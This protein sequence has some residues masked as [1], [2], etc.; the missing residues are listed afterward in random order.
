MGRSQH[1]LSMLLPL[2]PLF[3]GLA[4]QNTCTPAEA[5]RPAKR[6]DKKSFLT[7]RT[8][9]QACSANFAAKCPDGY[10]KITNDSLGVRDCRYSIEIRAYS[11]SVPG[12]RHICR[13]DYLQPQC[14]PGHWG[15]DCMECPGGA[16]SPC[17]GR[18]T[19]DEGMEG[20]GSCSCRAGFRGT[21]CETCEADNVFGPNCSSVC[22][23]V[24]GVCNS[25][26]HGDGTCECFSAYRGP[27]C[28]KPIPE[29]VALLCPENS[30]CSPSSQ[31]ETKLKCKC[32]PGY[33]GDGQHCKPINPC[34]KSIC[35][36]HA[37]CTYLGPN[38]H[39][40]SCQK[41]YRGDGQVCLPV[42]PCQTN[43]GNCSTKSTVCKY[44]GP[45]QSHCEC[46]EHYRDFVPGV[47]CS[48]I[49]VC[50]SNNPCHKNANCS[51][52]APGQARCTCRKGYMGDGLTCYGN[53][54][55]RLRE[56]N[57]E[58]RG[59]WQGRLTSFISIL[60]RTYAWPLSNLGPFTV[61]LP[62]DKGLKGF[63][64]KE[65]L[66][67]NEVTR[68][69]V[70]LHIIAGQMSTGQMNDTATF[71]TLTGKSGEIFNRDKDSQLKLKLD[72]GEK[73]KIIQGD[74][75]ASNGLIH[76][77][78]RAMDK[79]EPT[80]ESNPEQTIMKILQPRFSRFSSLL[81]KTNVGHVLDEGGA[82]GP[83]TVFVP[84]NEALDSM[85]AGTIDYLLSP[86]GS[87]KLLELVRYH[88]VAFTQLEVAT[89]ISTPHIRT[90]A[91][92]L[93]HF[94]TTRN[95]RILVNGV[96][97]EETEVAAKNGRIYTL[98][99]VLVPPSIVPILPHRCDETKRET[100]LGTCVSCSFIRWSKCP[101][102]SEP[103]VL[104]A[105]NCVYRTR[106]Q[107]LKSGCAQYCNAT[108]KIPKCCSGFFGP[109]CNPCP[110]G[111]LNPCS[112][113]GQCIDGLSGNGTCI[114]EDGFQGSRCQ[115]CSD[116]NRYGPRCNRTCLC[117]HGACD[118]RIDSDGACLSGT[119]REGTSGRFC[120]KKPSA[121]GPYVQLCH[122]HATCEYN[123]GTAS[124]VCNEG[125]EGDGTLCSKKDPC[126]G[127]TSRG[128]CSPNADCIR[129]GTGAHVCVCQQGWTGDGRD[130]VAINNCLLPGTGGCHDNA[131]C[132]YVG[133]GQNECECKKGFRGNGIDCEPVISCLEQA[134]KCHPLATC[135]ADA[136]GVWSC[137]CREG[138]EGNGLLCYGNVL[139]ELSR[140]SEAAAFY[141]W[142]ND[143]SL[144][145]MLSATP[146]LTVLVPS[147]Q[148]IE[149]MDKNERTFWLSRNNIPALI[150]YHTVRGTYGGADLQNLSSS[151]MLATSLQGS[152]LHLDKADGNITIEGASIVDGDSAAT[153]GVIHIINKVLV[154]QRSL[155]GSLPNLLTRLDQMPD[156]SIFR[157]YIIQYNLAS[158]IEAADAYT[159]FAPNNKAIESYIREKKA[160]TLEE[161]ILRYHV[162]LEEKLLKNDLHN[163]MHRETML[164]FSYLLGFFLHNDQLYVN[165]API[166][167]SN[168]ATDK[169]VIHGLGKVLEIQKNRCDENNSSIVR[170]I[171][172]KCSQEAICPLGTKPLG[173]TRKCIYTIYFMGKRSV[174]LGCQPKCVRT[175]ITKACCAGFFGPQCQACPRKDQNVCSGNGFCLDGV[176][177]VG[178]CK[179][180]QGFN[181]TACETCA[182]GKYGVHCD[183]ACACVH[184]RCSQG[185]S[186]DGSCDCEVGWRGV[187]CDIEITKDNCNGTCHTSA[188]CLLDPDGKASCKCAAGFQGNGTFCT[189]INACEVSNGGCS[190]KADCKRTTPGNRVCVCKAGYTGDGIVCLEI[191]PCLENNGGC[192]KNAECTQTGPNQAI[193]NC[194][195]KF[196]G[197]GKACTLINVC[198]TN[199]GG[200]S[201][202]ATCT[203]TGQDE[204]IC[205]CKQN[206]TGDG[207]VCRS[208]IYGEL[209]KNPTTS[210]YFFQL[211]E[212]AVRELAGPGPF[213]VFAPSS[214]S[215]NQESRIKDWDA[216]GLMSQVLRYHVV[217]CQQLLL[218]NLKVTTSAVTLQGEPIAIS[219]SQGTVFIN[220][221][222]V[223]SGDMISTNGVIHIIDRLLSPQNLLVTPKDASGR[224][225]NLT[226][227]A[228]NHSYTRFSKLIQDSGLLS[229]I[230]DPIHT[231]VTLF[232]PTDKALQALPPEQRDFLFDQD[233][234]DKLKE[235]L[236]FHVIR[237]SKALASDLP[238]SASWK[239][240]QGSELSV[241]CGTGRDVG[242][243]FLNGQ[244]CRIIQRG[245]LF[246]LGV[247]YGIDCLLTNPTLGGR[248]D[249]FTTFNISGDCGSCVSTPR[250][251]PWSKPK[252]VKQ[253][254]LYNP[255]PFGRN[256]EGCRQLCTLVIRLPRCCKGYF[257]PHCQ[258][259]PGGPDTPCNNRGVC[260][261]LYSTAGQCQCN[262]G[263]NGTACELCWPGRFGPDCQPCGCSEHGQCDE[264]IAG[265]GQCF[266][267][268]GWTGRF[269]DTLTVV[270]P[271]CIPPC[272]VHAT[273]MENNTCVCNLNYEGDGI[274]CT[275]VDFCKQN[276]GGCAK[277]AK[278][279][280]QGTRVS[281]SCKK[282]YQGDGYSCT[283]VDPCADGINGGCHEHATCR[284][285]GPGR[286]KCECKSHYVGDGVDCEPEQLPLDRCLQDNG[287]CHP[288]ANCADLHFQDTTVGVF[289]LRSPLGQY[290][291]TFD[292]AKEACANEAASMAT[293]NQLSYAQKASYHLCSAGWLESGR[294]A[295]PTTYASQKCGSNVVGI[296]DYGNRP[297]RSEMWDV[298]C[299]RMKDVNCTCKVGYVGDGF[300]CSGNMLQVLMSLSSLTDFLA[301]VLAYSN[302]SARGRAFLEHLT[303]LS[304]RGTLF[305]PQNSG[306]ME[307]KS[308]S[309]RDIEHHLT[310]VSISFYDDL[311][312]GTVLRTRLGS[313][314]LITSR[315]DQ[316]HQE[317]RFVDGRA[318]LQWDII[319]SNGLIHVISEPL[320]A[321]HVPASPAHTSLGTGVVCAVILVTGAI[322]LVAYSYFRL[323]QR[324]TGFQRFESEEDIDV[325]A[326]GKQHPENVANPVYES[327]S[328]AAPESS[329]DP[330]PDAE[331]QEV[332]SSDP[333][334][335]LRP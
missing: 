332:E 300:S 154:P 268:A 143:A 49:N 90:M 285:T 236:K 33:Q 104:F 252:G 170:G 270:F 179:C 309:G 141:Q 30:R 29:C 242:E 73:V 325:L 127:S 288:D 24:H 56:L 232:W 119:C 299:Y 262:T 95:G 209:P 133:P 109:D 297:N 276:N 80:L 197:D 155:T 259:C 140:L 46:K 301:E 122:I 77:L 212:H 167:Y 153:N 136:S 94:N 40:C 180:E 241:T 335:A 103:M 163:G 184:G 331:E 145:S 39:R 23:C 165:D 173:E 125:Y 126:I 298:F 279:S 82:G 172:G 253:K 204:R 247:A 112:G 237:D 35:H 190:A 68:Y 107:N 139:V 218:E 76:I 201:P 282:G 63:N 178:T 329:C 22:S 311:T 234:K 185:P 226:T 52:V 138:Y 75:A 118:N 281:C 206:Y 260:R 284:M 187:H 93:V 115:F 264:G 59:M 15:P 235:Y 151:N 78:D 271:V 327:S 258:A 310:N 196:T 198:L 277:A 144:Q 114:C 148:A 304:I 81:E 92:Q 99:G 186:G 292:K 2:I 71:Y 16:E 227:V 38:R 117:V 106:T 4:V 318:I 20:T 19:C 290:K 3:L 177:G 272:S 129:T 69:F 60:D 225:L 243:L 61:L 203:H 98:T 229:V 195:P 18:G 205:T 83:Y 45:G 111:F 319:A 257:L 256:L 97:V 278:C 1:L 224:V 295:Y 216:Q 266:C 67:N 189:A 200:C 74:I 175:V 146:N 303:D 8:E 13:K 275:A 14:C 265:S 176:N 5:T 87:R 121:C 328:S 27:R 57:M 7:I 152:F 182:E 132:L 322:A 54:M 88:I 164:G 267:E 294:V 86:E 44:D 223:L 6:C 291:L 72:R 220:K 181:G 10:I 62:S 17:N 333:L 156:Y 246:D 238:R 183:Q 194:L 161:D 135:Q 250:C 314:L 130:C 320:K 9:C 128:G 42:D 296:V 307:N 147:R 208:S 305:V 134:E 159:V 120:D 31:E 254:C 150:K 211:Q 84:S 36:P 261:D 102:D 65:L 240:L 101:A 149:D 280:Q 222:K 70:K 230:T 251:P 326:F 51:M 123:E 313:Q 91:N 48:M 231:P 41:G 228:V 43:F 269:C 249:T 202:F 28:D 233:N 283:E 306:L 166:N 287:Q 171:C 248:C 193:C 219:V 26:L 274:T 217:A 34:L 273:C 160:T 192:D 32:L 324:T 199:N 25:G 302:S 207:F 286:H 137:V 21:A 11:L 312:N 210:Q 64:L 108:M 330:F 12:C 50:E 239:T 317:T 66:M 308:L 174:F 316:L 245:L 142:I 323:N 47:G 293:Y 79:L 85:K 315:Q 169:G 113:N 214:A 157:G 213:T 89:L 116:P 100:R 37:S 188:N 263:F 215:F 124:C 191:N 53:I 334:G 255:L 244:Q 105:R 58:P 162:V 158:A 96:A 321:P 221:A 55:E 289:H 110:G 168:V 131:T